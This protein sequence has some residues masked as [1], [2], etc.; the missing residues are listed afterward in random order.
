MKKMSKVVIELIDHLVDLFFEGRNVG[1]WQFP[2]S[3]GGYRGLFFGGEVLVNEGD[4]GLLVY[5]LLFLVK[6]FKI[7]SIA[8]LISGNFSFI[9]F[10]TIS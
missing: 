2:L 8:G 4:E 10:H 3:K 6:S 7:A 5:V 9:T 1:D